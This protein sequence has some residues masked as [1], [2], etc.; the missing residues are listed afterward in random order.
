MSPAALGQRIAGLERLLGEKLFERTTRRVALTPAGERALPHAQRILVL[1]EGLFESVKADDQLPYALTIGTR[2]ELGLSWMTPAI[3]QLAATDPRRQ[4]DLVFGDNEEL[5]ARLQGHRIDAAISSSRRMPAHSTYATLHHEA[6]AFVASPNWLHD[7]PI[8]SAHDVQSHTLIDID[9]TL[10]LFRY[11]VDA[12]PQG[13]SWEFQAYEHLGTIAA[14]RIHLLTGAG[15]AVLPEYYVKEDL[16]AGR[17]THVLP[18]APL[19]SDAFRLIWL[20]SHPRTDRIRALVNEL[21][22][23]PLS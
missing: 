9:P 22:A 11:F 4:I 6:Y 7:R 15:V 23:L 2:F 14:I 12:Q 16:K 10:P 17:L 21:R 5:L 1:E 19:Q 20:K 8:E 18:N 3:R 13:D